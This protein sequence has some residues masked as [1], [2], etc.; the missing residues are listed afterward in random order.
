VLLVG[1]AGAIYAGAVSADAVSARTF[2][3]I[4]LVMAVVAAAGGVLAARIG[5]S[6]STT[7]S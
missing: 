1:L 5:R 6:V 3:T 2:T 4:W 7:G